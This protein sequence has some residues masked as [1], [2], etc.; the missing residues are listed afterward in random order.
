LD[1]L[2]RVCRVIRSGEVFEVSFSCYKGV[3]VDRRI[4]ETHEEWGASLKRR[5]AALDYAQLRV[6][7]GQECVELS[8]E[9][10]RKHN[11][12]NLW[13]LPQAAQD[14]WKERVI[15]LR[16]LTEDDFNQMD[17]DR[18]NCVQTE[19]KTLALLPDAFLGP[20]Q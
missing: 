13:D 11:C 18:A 19:E 6:A 10:C 12:R 20:V 3:K 7:A 15:S 1:F 16:L 4:D 8:I 9:L 17:E 5:R 14:E 2:A